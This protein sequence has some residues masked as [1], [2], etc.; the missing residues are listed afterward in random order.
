[1]SPEP[2]D[3]DEGISGKLP[4]NLSDIESE[5]DQDE[6]Q[7]EEEEEKE[8]ENQLVRMK[9]YPA[10]CPKTCQTSSLGTI[11]KK[12]RRR[13][14]KRRR[15]TCQDE[16]ISGKLPENL[17]DIESDDDLDEEQEVEEEEEEEEEENE[18]VTASE[19]SDDTEEETRN[20]VERNESEKT[21]NI[22]D[23]VQDPN[24]LE[25][26][27]RTVKIIQNDADAL[28]DLSLSEDEVGKES[29]DW[30]VLDEAGE[31]E[32]ARPRVMCSKCDVSHEE[33]QRCTFV[34]ESSRARPARVRTLPPELYENPLERERRSFRSRSPP[35]RPT[36]R[37]APPPPSPPPRRVAPPP[38]SPPSYEERIFNYNYSQ[39][40]LGN[41]VPTQPQPQFSPESPH[42]PVYYRQSLNSL[43]PL[44]S[45]MSAKMSSMTG[46][47]YPNTYLELLVSNVGKVLAQAGL[48]LRDLTTA[49]RLQGEQFVRE[50]LG[51]EL[52]VYAQR[53]P[54]GLNVP[55]IIQF[56]LEYLQS[57][58]FQYT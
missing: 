56:T 3:E 17:S 43:Q 40:E 47:P 35:T 28:S 9:T 36:R 54:G 10:S 52:G 33:G 16:D 26:V 27:D 57:S 46:Q 2:L 21:E 29:S 39:Q 6:E 50:V 38:P 4:E 42:L 12:R 23:D 13:K 20:S 41:F 48:G 8:D 58:Q 18:L 1:M 14:R 32:V 24:K 53:Y 44:Q 7:G 49:F 34:L 31:E 51:R 19:E 22:R 45:Y 30:V 5:D 55:V 25:D 11:K 15:I 37:V